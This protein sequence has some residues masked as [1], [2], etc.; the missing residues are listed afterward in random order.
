LN[1]IFERR[2]SPHLDPSD[3]RYIRDGQNRARS[4]ESVPFKV[5]DAAAV[6][7]CVTLRYIPKNLTVRTEIVD[8]S[9]FENEKIVE[10]VEFADT[11]LVNDFMRRICRA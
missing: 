2:N 1:R 11:A 7:S 8:L 5:G 10:L 3:G 9:K 4:R 6:H